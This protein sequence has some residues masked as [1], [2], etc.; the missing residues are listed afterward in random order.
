[1]RSRNKKIKNVDAVLTADWHIRATA[2]ECRLDDFLS[3]MW[4]K[5]EYVLKL[6]RTHNCP[7]LLAGDLGHHSQ[8]PNWL[9]EK[10]QRLIE[11]YNV[12]IVMIPGQHDLPNHNIGL[13]YKSAVGILSKKHLKV[14]GLIYDINTSKIVNNKNAWDDNAFLAIGYPYGVEIQKPYASKEEVP[15]AMAHQMVIDNKQDWPGQKASTATG[16]LRKFSGYKLILT[17]DNH[18]PFV[19]KYKGRLLV[20]P[21]SLMR[22]TAAQADHK[23][24]VYLWDSEAN[25]VEPFY[26]P[27]DPDVIDRTHIDGYLAPQQQ[28]K[29]ISAYVDRLDQSYELSLSYEKNLETHMQTNDT[30]T[31]VTGRVW[32]AVKGD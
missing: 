9:I 1:M 28:D 32:Q 12:P 17:G 27:I 26:L 2:P 14:L 31:P 10:L 6:T 21:G 5:V 15:I 30:V 29:R 18:K 4:K 11:K 8:W 7:I 19:V 16:L 25:E 20:N 24:R 23:P 13:W 22:T 3:A